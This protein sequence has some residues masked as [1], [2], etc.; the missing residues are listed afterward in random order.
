MCV[1]KYSLREMESKSLYEG[2]LD[3]ARRLL[4]LASDDLSLHCAAQ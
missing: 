1:F 3:S 4:G 2:S